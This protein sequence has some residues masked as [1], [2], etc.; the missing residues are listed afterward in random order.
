MKFAHLDRDKL[1]EYQNENLRKVVK[2]AYDN[3]PFYHQ[4][5]KLMKIKPRDIRTVKDLNK[6]PVLRKDEIN[7]NINKIISKQFHV[8]TLQRL[9]T[10][11]STGRP[12]QIFINKQEDDFR[13][14]KHL[15]ANIFCGQKPRDRYVAITAPSH[16]NEVPK[17]LRFM[18]I[19]D[20]TFVSVFDN[21]DTQISKIIELR[22]K[23]LAGY[24]SSLLLLAKEVEKRGIKTINPKFILGGAELLDDLSRQYIE[25]VFDSPL[26]DQYAVMEF[27][28]IAWQCPAR[29]QYHIDSYALIVQ[30]LDENG[31]EVSEGERG[32]VV[33]TSLF[34]YAMPFIRYSVGD[35]GIP[36]GDDCPCG[37]TLPLMKMIEG[38]KDSLLTL[39]DGRL[40]SPRT[41]TI[42]MNMFK[43]VRDI[44]QFRIIQKDK[45]FFVLY[46]KKKK[47]TIDER[48]LENAL[49]N[50][51]SNMLN[52]SKDEVTF[53]V[54]F[55]NNI[56]FDQT[57]KFKVVVSELGK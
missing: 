37:L 6:L 48:I 41:F 56:S 35:I 18:G 14:A 24:S 4:K 12:L 57:G 17:F 44:D 11:G 52:L 9:S 8:N 29:Q 23:I 46:I 49:V 50:H 31:D 30:F 38:R 55:C 40:I 20:R 1:I 33:C 5:L 22:P 43:F 15:M 2:Y 19:F 34:N 45:D 25:E 42:A 13:K 10:S 28:R 47:V 53:K 7:R 27:D 32:E 36:S 21:F 54:E 16:F 26:Y 3:V 39:P 51:F